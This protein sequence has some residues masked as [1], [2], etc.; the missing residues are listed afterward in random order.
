M[1]AGLL[2]EKLPEPYVLHL[3]D[4]IFSATAK[5][6]RRDGSLEEAFPFEG[7]FCVTALVAYDLLSAIKVLRPRIDEHRFQRYLNVIRPLIRFVRNSDETHGRI[8]NHLMV[9]ALV[10]LDWHALTQDDTQI[11]ARSL[12]D[13]IEGCYSEEGWF[14]EYDGADAGYQTITHWFL[15]ELC[16]RYEQGRFAQYLLQA[17]KFL[18]F[19]I[20][21]DGSFGGTYG[22]RNTRFFSPSGFEQ[23]AHNDPIAAGVAQTM[24]SSI[25]K[26]AVVNLSA[27]DDHNLPMLFNSYCRAAKFLHQRTSPVLMM[28]PPCR[29]SESW[30]K[31]FPEAGLVVEN[32]PQSY[33]VISWHKGGVV[34]H[35][36][37]DSKKAYI[38]CGPVGRD[39]NGRL[40]CCQLMNPEN[41]LSLGSNEYIVTAPFVRLSY[42]TPSPSQFLVLRSACCTFM[43]LRPLRE[44]IKRLLVQHLIPRS[45]P[46]MTIN[47]RHIRIVNGVLKIEDRIIENHAA[48]Q[49][50]SMNGQVFWAVHMASQGYWQI[51]DVRCTSSEMIDGAI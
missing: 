8:S 29:Q 25:E 14:T 4:R 24:R 38:D 20:H 11:K 36:V 40:F 41:E 28:E 50:V 6:A 26:G 32:S 47:R 46:S 12:L 27:V 35:F 34:Y 23:I 3:V 16:E 22:S 51:G 13:R 1:D 5:I 30:S 15:A 45:R 17:T 21:P 37:K 49:P 7:S 9:A 48:L 42:P 31:K 18:S 33:T 44:F 10:L 39:S 2:P 19:F 43:R